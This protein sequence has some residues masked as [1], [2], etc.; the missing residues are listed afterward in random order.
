MKEHLTPKSV[1][2]SVSGDVSGQ[3]V[4]G[5]NNLVI[6]GVYGGIVNLVTPGKQPVFNAR[7][8][9]V[10]LRPRAFQGLLDREDEQKTAVNAL[11]ISESLSISGEDGLGKTALM[12]YLAYNSPGDN[13]P[14]GIIYLSA[15]GYSTEDLQEYIFDSFFEGDIAVKPTQAQRSRALQELRALILLDD[16]SLGYDDVNQL[17]NS[18]PQSNF[19]LGSPSRC[20]WGEGGCIELGGLPFKEALALLERELGQTLIEQEKQSA[21]EFCRA[22]NGNPLKI[23][24]AAGLHRHG[25]TFPEILGKLQASNE[26]FIQLT[27]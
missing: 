13:F 12:R 19:I 16:L 4:V 5:N 3:I 2:I 21:E 25:A 15:R 6:G 24:Q 8:K 10:L 18:V 11:R 14:D 9:P 23:L 22:V 1:N 20:L 27:R 26:G 7:A 17:I